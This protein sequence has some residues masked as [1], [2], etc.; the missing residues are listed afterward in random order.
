MTY[1]SLYRPLKPSKCAGIAR[2]MDGNKPYTYSC[3]AFLQELQIR[4]RKTQRTPC[5]LLFLTARRIEALS[6]GRNEMVSHGKVP[7]EVGSHSL[8][9]LSTL[10]SHA[11]LIGALETKGLLDFSR[12]SGTRGPSIRS[13]LT[14]VDGNSFQDAW[15]VPPP[16]ADIVPLLG[17][18]REFMSR[19]LTCACPAQIAQVF[20][21]QFTHL[22][23]LADGNGRFARLWMMA[24]SLTSQDIA[25]IVLSLMLVKD[26]R[27]FGSA[28]SG[29]PQAIRK[30]HKASVRTAASLVRACQLMEEILHLHPDSKPWRMLVVS[31]CCFGYFSK[32][33]VMAI[34]RGGPAL[35]KKI[36]L[37]ASTMLNHHTERSGKCP[38]NRLTKCISEL[39]TSTGIE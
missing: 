17:D 8:R 14:W 21:F 33:T 24:L 39:R 5:D 26:R 37:T 22:H 1:L 29:N 2:A 30:L 18:L 27:Q 31:T 19:E 7:I 35:A 12:N 15:L 32:E 16:T 11:A 34:D 9:M 3:P 6:S 10:R 20:L 4:P 38:I 13:A 25:G 23:P 28:W 36:F